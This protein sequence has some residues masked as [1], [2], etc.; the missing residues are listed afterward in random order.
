MDWVLT[1][2]TYG[3]AYMCADLY[4]RCAVLFMVEEDKMAEG[5]CIP[6]VKDYAKVSERQNQVSICRLGNT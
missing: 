6:H 5:E 1:P 3:T 4:L 2:D